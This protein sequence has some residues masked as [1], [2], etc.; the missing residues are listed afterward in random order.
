MGEL[1]LVDEELEVAPVEEDVE[2]PDGPRIVPEPSSGL[3]KEVRCKCETMSRRDKGRGF[4][5]PTADD[6][7]GFQRFSFWSV[8]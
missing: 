1:E 8:C 7:L 3:A 5:P 4:P 6:L 2:G